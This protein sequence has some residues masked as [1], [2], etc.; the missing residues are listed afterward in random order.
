MQKVFFPQRVLDRLVSEGRIRLDRNVLTLLTPDQPSF[1]LEPGYRILRTA[2]N[3]PDPHGLVDKIRYEKDL[4]AAHAE[5]YLDSLL[6][7]DTAY[8]VEPGFIG[9]K[10]ELLDRLSD[11]ELLARFLLDNLI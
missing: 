11:A 9:E 1:D 3:G 2:D 10:K 6:Y 4:K 5:L 8:A 7:G